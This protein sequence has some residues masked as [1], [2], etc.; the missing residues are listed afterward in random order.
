MNGIELLSRDHKRILF[1]ISELG[2]KDK[3]SVDADDETDRAPNKMFSQLRQ[4]LTQHNTTEE[5]MLFPEL[6]RFIETRILVDECYRDHKRIGG[7]LRE[8]E[9]LLEAKPCDHWDD[10][11]L[12]LEEKVQLHVV[13]EEDWLFPRAKLLL[14]DAK[15]EEMFFEIER[16]RSSQSETDVKRV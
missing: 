15:L 3:H 1:L 14:G 8:I 2:R 9:K 4:T 13:R 5:R 6:D 16:T 12:E 10:L 11:L 7:I